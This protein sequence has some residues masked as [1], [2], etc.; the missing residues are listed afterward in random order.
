MIA[1][2]PFMLSAA[3]VAL[4][5]AVHAAAAAV[6]LH[7]VRNLGISEVRSA[8]V[9]LNL[10]QTKIID[11]IDPK[12][13]PRA[14]AAPAAALAAPAPDRKQAV[15]TRALQ[16]KK[17][18]QHLEAERLQR[19]LAVQKQAWL[20]RVRLERARHD[21]A[22][23]DDKASRPKTLSDSDPPKPAPT[24]KA[25]TRQP[26]RGVTAKQ[27]PL[28]RAEPP[29]AAVI[30]PLPATPLRD[31][32]AKTQKPPKRQKPVKSQAKASARPATRARARAGAKARHARVSA[33][34]GQNR[35]YAL[36]VRQKIARNRPQAS[37]P[38][39]TAVISFGL[40]RAGDLRYAKVA[41]SSGNAQFD[42]LALGAV[43]R[44]APF[45]RPPAGMSLRQ[46]AY[47]I[48]FKFE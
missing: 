8:A 14:S 22:R 21:R 2:P 33:N 40:N 31:K 10:V 5:L 30:Q 47:R 13:E 12:P 37:G 18:Q 1:R 6:M 20:E 35:S 32:P 19:E 43:R 38:R 17:R 41:K 16:E 27:T 46:L 7:R 36:L 28:A 15:E 25:I 23:A 24:V 11:A 26:A 45:P 3:C 34:R 44:A 42:R 48:P 39:G 4:A 9:S 29:L